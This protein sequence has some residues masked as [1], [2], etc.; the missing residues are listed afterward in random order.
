MSVRKPPKHQ[1]F[2]VFEA[3][4]SARQVFIKKQ[5]ESIIIQDSVLYQLNN[6]SWETK[7]DLNIAWSLHL[8]SS[9]RLLQ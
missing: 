6:N 1:F 4:F 5:I 2:P 9:K 3:F 7:E 8:V